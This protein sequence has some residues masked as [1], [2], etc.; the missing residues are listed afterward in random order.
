MYKASRNLILCLFLECGSISSMR[1]PSPTT[2]PVASPTAPICPIRRA[3]QLAIVWTSEGCVVEFGAAV[4]A[5]SLRMSVEAAP[6]SELSPVRPALPSGGASRQSCEALA[7]SWPET[8]GIYD[9]T[10]L[11]AD[12]S[13]QATARLWL[14]RK[15]RERELH[16]HTMTLR[17]IYNATML[18][19][20]S[21]GLMVARAGGRVVASAFAAQEDYEGR[22]VMMRLN[23]DQRGLLWSKLG[24]EEERDERPTALDDQGVGEV[25]RC[26]APSTLT[27]EP[28]LGEFAG[29]ASNTGRVGD[30]LVLSGLAHRWSIR[31]ATDEST[32]ASW[33]DIWSEQSVP[34]P[35]ETQLVALVHGKSSLRRVSLIQT[36]EC[37]WV[38]RQDWS[39]GLPEDAVPIVG[40]FNTLGRAGVLVVRS[41]V[42]DR[43]RLRMQLGWDGPAGLTLTDEYVLPEGFSFPEHYGAG[44]RVDRDGGIQ[45]AFI[46]HLPGLGW[47]LFEAVS[48]AG[49]M[50]VERTRLPHQS[51]L[52]GRV[53]YD[54]EQPVWVIRTAQG[55]MGSGHGATFDEACPVFDI[56]P[57]APFMGGGTVA[58]QA[59]PGGDIRIGLCEWR[60]IIEMVRRR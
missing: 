41:V 2:V 3:D 14:D 27:W 49:A 4:R 23:P 40:A 31:S 42:G 7:G 35:N 6:S 15:A 55:E 17:G 38:E 57:G 30:Q 5:S 10:V 50:R 13:R 53:D 9:V 36:P 51:I 52:V 33:S 56:V 26:Y 48:R 11:D 20:D 32:L 43:P 19:E 37:G 44:V 18:L 28:V 39:V 12:T 1:D 60:P 22:A 21:A 34:S 29:L 24:A 8:S 59:A 16:Q 45:G 25:P 46:G 47:S 58:W 54:G